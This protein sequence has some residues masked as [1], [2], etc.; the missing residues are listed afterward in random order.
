M[1]FGFGVW[2]MKLDR[3]VVERF[4]G[5]Q[6]A[7]PSKV[8]S[9]PTILYPG[10]DWQSID[11]RG[12]LTRLGYREQRAGGSL[13]RGSYRWGVTRL[14]LH[15][16]AFDHPSRPEP[17]RQVEIALE[18]SR[19]A[20]IFDLPVGS[21]GGVGVER[22]VVLLEPELVGAYYGPDRE[23]RDL[24]RNRLPQQRVRRRFAGMILTIN[25]DPIESAHGN[26]STAPRVTRHG[27]LQ[28]SEVRLK[29]RS[30][31]LS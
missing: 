1:G 10:L 8:M 24:V 26:R 6:F 9:A 23:Q 15:L 14:R 27:G 12:T 21:S 3:R 17:A 11:L 20:G 4:E 7:V 2:L 28:D 30:E 25:L 16:H 5:L 29:R 13:S 18:G 31:R 22:G 19:I